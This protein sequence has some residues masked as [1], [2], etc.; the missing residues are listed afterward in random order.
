M[1]TPVVKRTNALATSR[2]LQEVW[3]HATAWLDTVIFG[4]HPNHLRMLALDS[5]IEMLLRELD[6]YNM[7]TGIDPTPTPAEMVAIDAL[8]LRY[9]DIRSV[10]ARKWENPRVRESSLRALQGI[11]ERFLGPIADNRRV[12]VVYAVSRN[13][14]SDNFLGFVE[15]HRLE[16]NGFFLYDYRNLGRSVTAVQAPLW[17]WDV[18]DAMTMNPSVPR[19]G[20]EAV[21]DHYLRHRPLE[22][23]PRRAW[24]GEPVEPGAVPTDDILA[25]WDPK[26]DSSVFKDIP[27]VTKTLSLL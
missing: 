4:D 15:A 26:N 13:A 19:P 20:N 27:A 16:R 25:L 9:R 23:D 24:V 5:D 2:E 6:E 18:A 12:R 17:T 11:H 3:E 1:A 21:H 7:S 14:W 22:G 8:S 10:M